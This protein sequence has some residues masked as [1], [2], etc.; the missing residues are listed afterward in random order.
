MVA[1]FREKEIYG[2]VIVRTWTMKIL[3]YYFYK[4]KTLLSSCNFQVTNPSR[5]H[6][7]KFLLAHFI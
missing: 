1:M 7:L 5:L 3:L 2:Q 6:L 4:F